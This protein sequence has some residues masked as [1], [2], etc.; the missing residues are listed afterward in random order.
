MWKAIRPWIQFNSC[1]FRLSLVE[2]K[3]QNDP[4]ALV[5]LIDGLPPVRRHCLNQGRFTVNWNLGKKRRWHYSLSKY[6][7]LLHVRETD[8]KMSYAVWWPFC[9]DLDVSKAILLFSNFWH[10][11]DGNVK[12]S[13]NHFFY[14]SISFSLVLG[15]PL[16]Y[17]AMKWLWKSLKALWLSKVLWGSDQSVSLRD[18]QNQVSIWKNKNPFIHKHFHI[19]GF[20]FTINEY[21]IMITQSVTNKT[22]Q[23]F[24]TSQGCYW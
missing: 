7:N 17:K 8:F 4:R 12:A 20:H 19:L 3:T 21:P 22:C 9:Y 11:P 6:N 16:L 13:D 1:N 18:Q 23:G 10:I 2:P 15:E 14:C 24:D 5:Q